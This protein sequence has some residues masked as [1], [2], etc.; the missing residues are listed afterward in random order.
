MTVAVD[1]DL[2][3][4]GQDLGGERRVAL[5]LLADEEERRAHAG[6]LQR[7]EGG[8]RSLG[9]GP[10][11]KVSATTQAS[12]EWSRTASARRGAGDH[13]HS[14]GPRARWPRPARRP[15][16]LSWRRVMA[17]IVLGVVAAGTASAMY[18]LGVAL[19]ALEARVMP[20]AQGCDRR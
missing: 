16:P 11:S 17:P 20:A 9:C 13:A 3:A 1:A 14:A 15:S 4:R 10:S 2:V 6:P 5:D 19:Q 12:L 18:D 7:G 8:R